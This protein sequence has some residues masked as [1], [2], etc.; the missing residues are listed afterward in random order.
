MTA[1]TATFLLNPRNRPFLEGRASRPAKEPGGCVFPFLAVFLIP[2]VAAGAFLLRN[3]ALEWT[4]YLTLRTS[5]IVTDAEVVDR[6]ISS[7]DDCDLYSLQYAFRW[8]GT[9]HVGEANVSRDDYE[10]LDIGQWTDVV[11]EPSHPERSRLRTD[12]GI[13][14]PLLLTAAGLFWNAI[15]GVLLVVAVA[16]LRQ[17]HI[18]KRLSR[19]G[20][21]V[22]GHIDDVSGHKDD[23]NDYHVTVRYRFVSP[24]SAQWVAGTSSAMRNDLKNQA[25]PPPDTPVA[26]LYADDRAHRVL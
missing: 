4:S 6:K 26:V 18:D 3:M 7:G 17:M 9:R 12:L 11:F 2:F 20:R 14:R 10:R 16:G 15:V 1:L 23:D 21:L 24:T 25:L 8:R 5:G 19:A 13:G 22:E